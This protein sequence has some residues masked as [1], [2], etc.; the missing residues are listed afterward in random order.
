MRISVIIES[1][2]STPE[3]TRAHLV[4]FFYAALSGLLR[5]T[6]ERKDAAAIPEA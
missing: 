5:W 3:D 6:L 1:I 2:H 4:E